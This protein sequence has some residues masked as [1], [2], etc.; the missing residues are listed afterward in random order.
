MLRCSQAGEV[1]G[2]LFVKEELTMSSFTLPASLKGLDIYYSDPKSPASIASKKLY[3]FGDINLVD[4]ISD[5]NITYDVLSFFQV[6]LSVFELALTQIKKV[7]KSKKVVDM[8]SGVGTIGLAVGASILVESDK[9]NIGHAMKNV[10]ST[11]TEVVHASS[12]KALVHI[13][14]D[15]TL[16][17]DPPRAGLHKDVIARIAEVRPPQVIYLSCNPATQARD[18]KLLEEN[19][20]IT[21]A[22]G[23]NFF[24]RTP[25]IESLVVLE[26]K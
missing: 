13:T 8:Y 20:R 25:H 14:S 1:V 6:N 3:S 7:I 21:Y 10:G 18:V 17:V 4:S 11:D 16:I 2:A 19:Y 15:S 23:Y 22:Q 5:I 26:L 9:N 12:E 24:P